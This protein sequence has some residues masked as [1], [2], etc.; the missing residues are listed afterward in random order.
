MKRWILACALLLSLLRLDAAT[1]KLAGDLKWEITEPRLTFTLDGALQNLDSAG[2]SGTIKLV[3]WATKA[4]YPST[5]YS[6]GEYNLGQ[7]SAGYQFEDFSVKTVSNV[8]SITGDYYFTI[9]VMEYTTAGWR[10]RLLVSTGTRNLSVGDFTTQKKW[11]IPATTVIA[12]PVKLTGKNKIIMRERATSL[13]NRFPVASQ[14]ETTFDINKGLKLDAINTYDSSPA[15]YTY[16][17]GTRK[18]KHKAVPAAIVS[19]TYNDPG[20]YMPSADK[21]ILYFHTATSGIYKSSAKYGSNTEVT[22]GV[23][24]LE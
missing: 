19:V 12:P 2:T 15:S 6:V 3:L 8:P 18:L 22:W 20:G 23:L 7:I 5:G 21:I 11:S 17:V 1:F 10:N 9:A 16:V 24:T 4:P 14:V 13:L